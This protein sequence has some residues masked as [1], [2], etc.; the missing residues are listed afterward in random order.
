MAGSNG[1]HKTFA[2]D[3][4]LL[5]CQLMGVCVLILIRFVLSDPF[6]LDPLTDRKVR[7]LAPLSPPP[8]LVGVSGSGLGGPGK[9]ST[10]LL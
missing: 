4:M 6:L 3:V 9:I 7:L 5:L 1:G 2:V 8:P 10:V